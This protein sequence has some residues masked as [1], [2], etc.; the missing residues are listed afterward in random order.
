MKRVYH[1]SS[2]CFGVLLQVIQPCFFFLNSISSSFEFRKSLKRLPSLAYIEMDLTKYRFFIDID[3]VC[4]FGHC[5]TYLHS[6]EILLDIGFSLNGLLLLT[7]NTTQMR[8]PRFWFQ[9]KWSTAAN[10]VYHSDEIPVDI[11]FS[12]NGLLLLKRYTTLMRYP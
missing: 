10:K 5:Y 8:Y 2:V 3:F 4:V 12:L 7:R 1:F 6:D 9:I 11:G